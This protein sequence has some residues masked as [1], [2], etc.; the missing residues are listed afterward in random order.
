MQ[1]RAVFKKITLEAKNN[2]F[3][4]KGM[5]ILRKAGGNEI[6]LDIIKGL[7]TI[8]AFDKWVKHSEPFEVQKNTTDLFLR[9]AIIRHTYASSILL[10]QPEYSIGASLPKLYRRNITI[11]LP[12]P[13]L[14]IYRHYSAI[15]DQRLRI[16]IDND[17]GGDQALGINRNT[18]RALVTGLGAPFLFLVSIKHN[19][20]VIDDL[21][22]AVKKK[23]D[24]HVKQTR[25]NALYAL[26][27]ALVKDVNLG[28]INAW[29]GMPNPPPKDHP[30]YITD[31]KLP[32]K[33]L[34]PYFPEDLRKST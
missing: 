12:K 21:R 10:D 24:A 2:P 22:E 15:H 19:D 7:L 26:V 28:K 16:T 34:L 13:L 31:D 20:P 11:D 27:E 5:D 4:N 29:P 18:V 32:S 9:N 33:S 6:P 8:N 30:L 1:S 23:R 3:T 17:L 25:D 14:A